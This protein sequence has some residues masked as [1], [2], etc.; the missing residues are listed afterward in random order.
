MACLHDGVDSDG[1]RKE[2]RLLLPWAEFTMAHG[3]RRVASVNAVGRGLTAR[4]RADLENVNLGQAHVGQRR[5]GMSVD[6]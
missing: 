5:D 1:G 6:R 3:R 2:L 4:A